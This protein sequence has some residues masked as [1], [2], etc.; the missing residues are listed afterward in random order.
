MLLNIITTAKKLFLK[1]LAKWGSDLLL[2]LHNKWC[3]K[4]GQDKR[5]DML[6]L[7]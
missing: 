3:T 5:Y 4:S 1:E 6:G 2:L 7:K